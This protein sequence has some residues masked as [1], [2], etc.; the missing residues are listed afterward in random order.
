MP[1]RARLDCDL[2]EE[3][4]VL[5]TSTPV[6]QIKRPNRQYFDGDDVK[7]PNSGVRGG[8]KPWLQLSVQPGWSTAK[9]GIPEFVSLRPGYELADR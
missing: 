9:S 5:K 2:T 7:Q 4:E 8:L 6:G 3:A 1:L